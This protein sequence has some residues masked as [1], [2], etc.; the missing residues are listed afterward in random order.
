MRTTVAGWARDAPREGHDRRVGGRVGCVAVALVLAVVAALLPADTDSTA[1]ATTRSD[2]VRACGGANSAVALEQ[3]NGGA[4]GSEAGGIGD[5]EVRRLA[6]A[7]RVDTAVAVSQETFSAAAAVVLARADDY[8][9]ALVGAPLA[10]ALRAPLLLTPGDRLP[11]VVADELHRLGVGEVVVLGGEAAV[12][13]RVE[14]ALADEYEV[15]R[16]AGG[17]RFAT[18]AAVADE[19]PVGEGAFVAEGV[20]AD[21][22]RGW[23]DALAVA[24]LAA[25]QGQPVLLAT[26]ERLP[27]PTRAALADREPDEAIIVGGR[28]A[29]SHEV[30][31]ELADAV[32]E[33]GRL[34]GADRF[35]TSAAVAD[36]AVAAGMSPAG[37]WLATGQAF[38]DALAAGPAVAAAAET[39]LLVPGGDVAAAPAVA[40]RLGAYRAELR[41]IVLLG[42]PAAIT[43]EAG[44]QL[45]GLLGGFEA[46]GAGGAV[47]SAPAV[48]GAGRFVAFASQAEFAAPSREDAQVFVRDRAVGATTL[49]S[50]NGEGQPADTGAT[51]PVISADG[52]HVAFTSAASNLVDGAGGHA[53]VFVADRDS[54]A[55]TLVSV[56]AGRQPADGPSGQPAI[57]ADGR[58][59]AFVSHA[60]NLT[61]GNVAAHSGV[62]VHDRQTGTTELVT[63][64]HDGAA[65]DGPSGPPSISGDG[66]L[67][68]FASKATNLTSDATS[69]S[70]E[71]HVYDREADTTERVS[72]TASE[73]DGPSRAPALS[74]NG[75]FLAFDTAA[76]NV[77]E[78]AG[79]AADSGTRHVIRLDRASGATTVVS[80]V[81]DAPSYA[82]TVADDGRVAFT[83]EATN[84]SPVW[85]HN[86]VEHVYEW[87][88]ARGLVHLS[89]DDERDAQADAASHS[90][91]ISANGWVVAY[92][93]PA[94]TLTATATGGI[95]QVFAHTWV[96]ALCISVLVS[97]ADAAADPPPTDEDTDDG[98]SQY[99]YRGGSRTP[100][101]FTPRPGK[102]TDGY[103]DNGLS[104]FAELARACEGN[105]KAQAL[106]PGLIA[107]AASRHLRLAADPGDGDHFF[108]QADSEELHLD[109]SAT[110]DTATGADHHW[111]TGVAL[112]TI[113]DEILCP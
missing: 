84:L 77:V 105:R 98:Q 67:V 64:A 14:A 47:S 9:D 58:Y 42:G 10:R 80:E 86:D 22:G 20:H 41:R 102:D 6:G 85:E 2:T 97:A 16:V 60:S 27:S 54:G 30:E 94:T 109:W 45:D 39:L 89:V 68:A 19:L 51:E 25:W 91:A 24:P 4:G 79:G 1:T 7:G 59:V 103:P 62:Y 96:G 8:A 88:D 61:S 53:D 33:V 100:R 106:D 28:A 92:A 113:V 104:V 43:G 44:E 23:P 83:S 70:A 3:H 35:A 31:R 81:A 21:P 56:G 93:S 74:P 65:V 63:Q 12:G 48:S 49:V 75:D 36:A 17:D 78:A 71:V 90:P 76:S 52:R 32:G 107:A 34:A 46:P 82:P 26:H 73:P 66:R 40:D 95:P 110:R 111:L 101:N 29:I 99:L 50:A 72:L 11:E 112:R 108:L 87:G 18:A 69:E 13:P 38:P 55:I 15:R 5:V 37:R 57:S